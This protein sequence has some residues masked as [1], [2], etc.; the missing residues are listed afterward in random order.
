MQNPGE[1]TDEK[2]EDDESKGGYGV[3]DYFVAVVT[4]LV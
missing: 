4:C 1:G 3:V 2:L